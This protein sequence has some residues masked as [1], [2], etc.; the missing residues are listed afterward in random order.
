[1]S[2][3]IAIAQN[4]V[5]EAQLAADLEEN[6]ALLAIPRMQKGSAFRPVPF[7]SCPAPR[8][9]IFLS[10]DSSVLAAG[11]CPVP[12]QK[13]LF[14][15]DPVVANGKTLQW[16]RTTKKNGANSLAGRLYFPDANIG[17]EPANANLRSV[18]SRAVRLIKSTYPAKSKDKPP[19][20]VGPGLF[21]LIQAGRAS[22]VYPDGSTVTLVAENDRKR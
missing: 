17:A 7:G 9:F 3:Q 19:V 4:E 22:L 2:T 12:D 14:T 1:M 13:G 15:L 10:E 6:A 21:D 8:Q 18:M 5:D 16:T 20:F 11:I